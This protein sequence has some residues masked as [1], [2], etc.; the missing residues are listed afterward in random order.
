[1]D[2]GRGRPQGVGRQLYAEGLAEFVRS[3]ADGANEAGGRAVVGAGLGGKALDRG[4]L[5]PTLLE[6]LA[7]D[8]H[9]LDVDVAF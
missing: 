4:T 3:V 6:T 2:G 7:D 8:A 1:V 5:L 9:R